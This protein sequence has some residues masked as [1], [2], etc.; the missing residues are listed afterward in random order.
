MMT[1]GIKAFGAYIP[2]VRLQR[3][4][5][6][7]AYS[8]FNPALTSLQQGERAIANWDE[9]A[10]TMGV[11]AARNALDSEQ[12]QNIDSLYFASTTFPFQD[13]QNAG[14]V[15]EALHLGTNLHAVD[16]TGSQRCGT[17]SLLTALRVAIGGDGSA[18]VIAGEKRQTKAAGALQLTS[19]DGAAAFLIGPGAGCATLVGYGTQSIDFVD[20]YRGQNQAFDYSWEERWVRDEGF[21]KIVPKAITQSFEH[22]NVSGSAIDHFCFPSS[23]RRV[24]QSLAKTLGIKEGAVRDNLQG[25]SGEAGCAHPLLMLAHALEGATPNQLILVVGFG[26]GCDA[27]LFRTTDKIVD[28][29]PTKTVS[30]LLTTGRSDDNYHRYLAINGLV[31]IDQGLRAE[32][33]KQTGLTTLYRNK[34]MLLGL[35]GGHCTA[36]DT[37]QYPKTNLCVNPECGAMNT[38]TDHPFSNMSCRLASYTAD[39]LTFSPDPPAYY[40]M[41]QFD[42]GGRAMM[43]FTDIAPGSTLV[44]GQPMQLMFR[45]KDYDTARGFRRYFWK[46][47]PLNNNG[48]Y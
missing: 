14:L 22:A 25:K 45:V 20:H 21:M 1:V 39:R 2:K 32:V 24:A 47:V 12:C 18:L 40:G 9:D 5:M 27:L 13:R 48:E 15:A 4:V 16:M 41:I 17:S 33:D 19:G 7:Q 11:E 6:A 31:T 43:D 34:D 46:A 42:Q 38:Q 36:C 23:P 26:Q 30:N 29:T 37:F 28:Q 8:W 3:A 35:I 10:L 44:V